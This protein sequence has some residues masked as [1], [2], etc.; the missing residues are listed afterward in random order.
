AYYAAVIPEDRDY[1]RHSLDVLLNNLQSE[2][3]RAE[4][5]ARNHRKAPAK[6]PGM[7]KAALKQ[8]SW[9]VEHEIEGIERRMREGDRSDRLASEKKRLGARLAEIENQLRL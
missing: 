3:D 2:F 7:D 6:A 9:K 5:W 1:R 4:A 8:E